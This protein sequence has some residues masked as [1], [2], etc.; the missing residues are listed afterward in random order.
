MNNDLSDLVD[1]SAT[2]PLISLKNALKIT[3]IILQTIFVAPLLLGI[4]LLLS[5]K[6]LGVSAGNNGWQA[7]LCFAIVI[8][9]YWI[10]ARKIELWKFKKTPEKSAE[11]LENRNACGTELSDMT[12]ASLSVVLLL[13]SAPRY[14]PQFKSL[15]LVSAL[16]QYLTICIHLSLII[17]MILTATWVLFVYE[18]QA[19]GAIAP[20]IIRL[21]SRIL[22]HIGLLPLFPYLFRL[23]IV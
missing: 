19:K 4:P 23:F 2:P 15:Y 7:Y 5:Y 9:F 13:S 17:F 10:I 1:E 11:A 3:A 6:L 21:L 16:Y 12:A 14:L 20:R 18:S 8:I 22:I